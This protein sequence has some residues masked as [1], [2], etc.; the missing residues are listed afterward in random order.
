MPAGVVAVA[1]TIAVVI[2]ASSGGD[3]DTAV[4]KL[5]LFDFGIE[6]DLEVPAGQV[7]LATVNIG[8]QP[9]NIG[10]RGGAI[11]NQVGPGG[12][13]ELDIGELA[14]GT[15]ELFCDIPGHVE[16]GMTVPLVVTAPSTSAG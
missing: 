14:P 10:I 6:G 12:T 4:A 5:Q 11:S 15:Y 9:H 7:H 2:L 1:V 3:D 13:I 16:Q 8:A